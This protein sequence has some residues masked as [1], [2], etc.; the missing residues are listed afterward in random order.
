MPT[1]IVAGQPVKFRLPEDSPIAQLNQIWPDGIPV[2]SEV[3]ID[4]QD[5]YELPLDAVPV[6]SEEKVLLFAGAI[7]SHPEILSAIKRGYNFFTIPCE[8]GMAA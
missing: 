5:C 2:K 3:S 7:A 8:W 4:G 1:N 6:D